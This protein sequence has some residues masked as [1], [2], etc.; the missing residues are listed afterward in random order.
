MDMGSNIA[1]RL[2]DFPWVKTK[3]TPEGKGL[4]LTVYP[5]LSPITGSIECLGIIIVTSCIALPSW[6]ILKE[7]IIHIPLPGRAIFLHKLPHSGFA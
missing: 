6:L 2:R 4:Y 1:L 7:L 3:G 5:E